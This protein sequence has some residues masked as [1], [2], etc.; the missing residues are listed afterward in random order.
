MKR[1]GMNEFAKLVIATE[2]QGKIREI[3]L[4]LK[5]IAIE[6]LSLKD[7]D[8]QGNIVE[9]G[10]TFE[11]NALKKAR[12][13]SQSCGM[14]TLAD[15]S[16]L[17]I[18]ALGGR[19]GVLSARYGGANKS[20]FD[21]CMLILEEMKSV[22]AGERAAQFVCAVALVYPDGIEMVFVGKC[23]GRITFEPAGSNGFGYDPIFFYPEAGVTFAEMELKEKNKVSHRAKALEQ[24]ADY[25][26]TQR[27]PL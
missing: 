9:D 16:G 6:V 20:D 4:L 23:E 3:K 25:F 1:C 21:K 7:L 18:D 19:P 5:S 10:I 2:N 13:I 15:D 14:M 11:Q 8:F 26:K 17:C 27:C 24:F 22:P 12:T